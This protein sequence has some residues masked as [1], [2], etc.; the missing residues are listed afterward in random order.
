MINNFSESFF[1]E[2]S[3]IGKRRYDRR[4]DPIRFKH[5]TITSLYIYLIKQIFRI[6]FHFPIFMFVI[7]S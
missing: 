5:R 6:E 3:V 4:N 1:I 7:F 2:L